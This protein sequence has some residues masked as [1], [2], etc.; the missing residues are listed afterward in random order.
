MNNLFFFIGVFI[1][2]FYVELRRLFWPL[3][4]FF[5]DKITLRITKSESIT[6]LTK[7]E[8]A[9]TLYAYQ[10]KVFFN[11]GF[12]Y[13]TLDIVKKC[14]KEGMIVVDI[15][16]NIGLYS[17]LLSRL[18]GETGKVYAFEPDNNTYDI[19][20]ENLK[21]S[22]CYNVEVHRI[23]LSDKKSTVILTKPDDKHGDAFN[24]I[25][26]VS[27]TSSNN[28]LLTETL[29]DFFYERTINQ[30]DFIKIDV[31]GAELLI[32][33]GAQKTL[34]K[35]E[36]I[37]IV[38]ECYEKFLLRFGHKI[39]DLLVYMSNLNYDCSNYDDWQWFFNKK[40]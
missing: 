38:S 29:D 30:I 6:I 15:G 17:I 25:K 7:G 26:E 12:E 8:I 4:A 21:M 28:S 14:V 11:R 5:S 33:R 3:R 19:L 39:S 40:K 18:V 2:N 34:F 20:I 36:N 32:L 35:S 1:L 10:P 13:K 31:E 16:A 23:A 27:I 24:Y 37:S 22:K 9:Q